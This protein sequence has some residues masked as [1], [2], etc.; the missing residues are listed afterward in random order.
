[1][2]LLTVFEMLTKENKLANGFVFIYFSLKSEPSLQAGPRQLQK[3]IVSNCECKEPPPQKK[4]LD[5]TSE[6]KDLMQAILMVKQKLFF[7]MS[8]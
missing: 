8:L 2:I 1:M 7:A 4:S 3:T 6:S 5:F